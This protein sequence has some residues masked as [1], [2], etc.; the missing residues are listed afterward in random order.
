MALDPYQ[1]CPCG[2]EKKLKFCCGADVSHELEKI[3]QALEGEHLAEN[4]GRLRQRQ[5][6]RSHQSALR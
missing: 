4:G 1:P 6:G 2:S 5:R 3:K